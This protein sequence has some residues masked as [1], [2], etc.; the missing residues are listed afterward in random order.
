MSDESL[1][2]TV[3]PVEDEVNVETELVIE[4]A[5]LNS[6]VGVYPWYFQVGTFERE[7]QTHDYFDLTF[8]I[9]GRVPTLAEAI[10][11]AASV[12]EITGIDLFRWEITPEE[13]AH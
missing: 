9:E 5:L 3:F 13:V 7:I 11:L 1:Q 12:S 8:E 4:V 2:D 6:G 10:E